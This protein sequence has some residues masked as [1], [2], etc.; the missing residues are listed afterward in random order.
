MRGEN[1]QPSKESLYGTDFDEAG[2]LP[3][4]RS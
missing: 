4:V 3:V 1:A 2:L